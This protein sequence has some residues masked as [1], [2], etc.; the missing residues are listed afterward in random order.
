MNA[1]ALVLAAILG[2]LAGCGS[3]HAV[4]TTA[5]PAGAIPATA[6]L[7]VSAV[8][9]PDGPL[10]AVA[11]ADGRTITR[12]TNP[13]L[14]LLQVLQT[15]GS[16]GLDF[17]RDV[18]PWLGTHAGIFLSS[19]ESTGRSN[20][21]QL[22]SLL[23]RSLLGGSSTASAFPF[24]ANESTGGAGSGQ[25]AIVLDTRDAE[26]ARS[27]L[28][29]QA[30]HAG[31]HSASY[32]G[33]A[34]QA[35]SGGVAFGVVE[36]F[37]VIG[38]ESGLRSVID[39]ALGG[40]S[41][42][43]AAGYAKLLASAPSGALAHVYANP[44]ASDSGG[45][46]SASSSG[47]TS[48]SGSGGASQR[49][50]AQGLSGLLRLLAGTRQLDV[51]LVPSTKSVA[52]DADTLASGSAGTPGGL[53]SSGAEG[54]RALGEL[55]GESWLAVG[56][57][58]TGSTLAEDVGALRT[59]ASLGASS[60]SG[61]TSPINLNGL[62]E[63]ILAPLSTLSANS[64]EARRDFQSWMGSAG[65]FASGSGLLELKGG[66]VI[67][68]KNPALSRAAVA[69]LGA[70]LRKAGGSVQP[71]S[72]RGT[73]A[74]VAAR[75]PGLPVALDIADGHDANG[76]A[77]FV[78]G[79]GEASVVAALSPSSTLSGA[80]SYGAGSFALGEGI[81]PS[82]TVDFATLLSL[83]EGV[84]LSEDPT[85]SKLVPYLRTFTTLAGGGKSLGGGI[86]RF[87]LVLGL[88]G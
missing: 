52:L 67:A 40:P 80:A 4:G 47:S 48:A 72:I 28:D 46:R 59:L 64:A 81:Q 20:G 70:S 18:A 24:G 54:A 14:Q 50:G 9:R 8:V 31:A 2:V 25:G 39:T 36:R 45:Q 73:D 69:K 79:L 15:P 86:E 51:S 11:L 16:P 1:A 23:Q 78:I 27:F 85:I 17:N 21:D 35:T 43:R 34:Y 7:Y 10:K 12:Q 49:S 55:P 13:Y 63:G 53:L 30:Q 41:L 22:L 84:G 6:P 82:L 62:L 57:G 37:A 65:I 61:A 76:K 42:A 32:R 66:V 56:L 60:S 77:K 38:S 71:V 19:L 74:S 33:V 3:S 29:S 75:L 88:Q 68:S 87:R 58:N 5:D 44:G 83:L 26:K